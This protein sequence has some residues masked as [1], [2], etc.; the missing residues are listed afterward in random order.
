M[1]IN[2]RFEPTSGSSKFFESVNHI[3]WKQ[4][5][6]LTWV[7]ESQNK[8][9]ILSVTSAAQRSTVSTVT[10][11]RACTNSR[12]L[13]SVYDTS[14]AVEHVSPPLTS[15]DLTFARLARCQETSHCVIV[16]G[17]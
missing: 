7:F 11:V 4:F 6:S 12:P 1:S 5:L 16:T 13:V 2:P 8:M 9:M 10:G 14:V 17:G 3:S 15:A